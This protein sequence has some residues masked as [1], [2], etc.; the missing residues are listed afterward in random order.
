MLLLI[1]DYSIKVFKRGLKAK[2]MLGV[3]KVRLIVVDNIGVYSILFDPA[4]PEIFYFKQDVGAS[5]GI[6]LITCWQS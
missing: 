5:N 3:F 4:A 6:D 2:S 1:N